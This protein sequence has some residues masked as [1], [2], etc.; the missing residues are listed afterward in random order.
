MKICSEHEMDGMVDLRSKRW[1][2]IGLLQPFWPHRLFLK[3][4]MPYI[5]C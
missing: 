1:G 3:S 5:L 2:R 4:T